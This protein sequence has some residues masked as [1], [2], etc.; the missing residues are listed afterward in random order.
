MIYI[1]IYIYMCIYIY[2]YI[3][4]A[5]PLVLEVDSHRLRRVLP[6]EGEAP[7]AAHLSAQSLRSLFLYF[8]I[9]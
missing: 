8:Y 1:Y 3:Y 5:V 4:M 9:I 7:A 6:L 2:I